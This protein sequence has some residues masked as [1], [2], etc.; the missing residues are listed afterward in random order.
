MAFL[1]R[2]LSENGY[3]EPVQVENES[4]WKLGFL[5]LRSVYLK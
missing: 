3:A 2:S 4:L 5:L 1:R